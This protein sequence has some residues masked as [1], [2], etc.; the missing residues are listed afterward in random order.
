MMA[1]TTRLPRP[2]LVYGSY[3]QR[4]PTRN[5]LLADLVDLAGHALVRRPW[6]RTPDF[7]ACLAAQRQAN[8]RTAADPAKELATV[9]AALLR[10]GFTAPLVARAQCLIAQAMEEALGKRPFDTQHSAAWAMLC[11]RLVEMDTG[12]G[13]SLAILMAAATA[14]LAGMPVHVV[15]ANDY[16]A[17]RDAQAARPVLERLGLNVAAIDPAAAPAQ[18]RAAYAC[19]VV[20]CTAR[21]LG[22]DYLRDR[23]AARDGR[24]LLRGLCLA[25]ID[26]AD[27]VLIDHA[28]TPL[29]IATAD[30]STSPALPAGCAAAAYAFSATL[31]AGADFTLQPAQRRAV[32]S[33][34]AV[35]RL[36]DLLAGLP[37]T[38]TAPDDVRVSAQALEQALVARHLLQRDR[39]YVVQPGQQPHDGTPQ[40]VLIDETTG[41]TL[42]GT[43]WTGGLHAFVALKEGCAP[44]PALRTAQG[45]SL[46]GLFSRYWKLGGVSGTLRESRVELFA[47][48]RLRVQRILPRHPSRRR[49]RG[50]RLFAGRAERADAVLARVRA[51]VAQGRPVLV[52]TDS[53]AASEALAAR[54]QRA[55]VQA[56][57]LNARHDAQEAA[58]IARA[59]ARGAVTVATNMAGRGTDIEPDRQA[60]AAGLH[61]IACCLNGSRRIDRQLLGR[62]ARNGRPG[63]CETLLALDD[64]MFERRL[65]LRT[66]IWLAGWCGPQGLA[67]P[68]AR[69]L[70]RG[71]QVL[72][73]QLDLL[74]RWRLVQH[75]RHMQDLLAGMPADL[76]TIKERTR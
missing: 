68:A 18:R 54:L 45:I 27:S 44:P 15:T 26:E 32:P 61:V 31:L 20:Y 37:D 43:H 29:I 39:H 40:V 3:P 63:S 49:D 57:V 66:R 71:V 30:G 67:G 14:G 46:Q 6:R 59:G 34:A 56:T 16:L 12:E 51:C 36:H 17:A 65:S 1:R 55:G 75:D 53:V 33:A 58:L 23:M 69:W 8:Q 41:R 50:L 35:Q 24:P 38:A 52:G 60:A 73:E 48:Y 70:A 62:T 25:L 7:Q 2:G 76:G 10:H 64:G 13:K 9:R 72:Q 47:F 21:E 42:P 22:F 5:G 4:H 74:Q 28:R 11:D 19:D